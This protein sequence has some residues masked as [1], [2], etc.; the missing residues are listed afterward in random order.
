MLR[1]SKLT[2]YAVV[3]MAQAARHPV[4]SV[5]SAVELAGSSRI[6]VPTT[7][8][9]LKILSR[10]GLLVSH[11]GNQGGYSLARPAKRIS[12][13][14]IV[15]IMEGPI[16]LTECGLPGIC[17]LE[18]ICTARHGWQ[19]INQTVRRALQALTLE[20]LARPRASVAP[21]SLGKRSP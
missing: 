7:E 17:S 5:R 8:K 6:P 19:Q 15:S 16:A 20:E 3:L 4:G 10:G 14:E 2:D 1:I 11:R 12:A 9:I 13:A 18:D 21:I